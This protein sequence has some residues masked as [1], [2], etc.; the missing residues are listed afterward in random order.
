MR[1]I[2][3]DPVFDEKL[4]FAT[5]PVTDAHEDALLR[6]ALP[7]ER[8]HVDASQGWPSARTGIVAITKSREMLGQTVAFGPTGPSFKLRLEGN[9]K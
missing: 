6:R 1:D 3:E 7:K 5:P 8:F 2:D 4:I 9:L